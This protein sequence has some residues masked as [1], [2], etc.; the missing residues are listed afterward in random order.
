M[1]QTPA[2]VSKLAARPPASPPGKAPEKGANNAQTGFAQFLDTKS[3]A[4]ELPAIQQAASQSPVNSRLAPSSAAPLKGRHDGGSAY[5]TGATVADAAESGAGKNDSSESGGAVALAGS[6]SVGAVWPPTANAGP[7]IQ[8]DSKPAVPE[9]EAGKKDSPESGNAVAL[10]LG[11]VSLPKVNIDPKIKNDPVAAALEPAK[12]KN[13]PPESSNAV[14]LAGSLGVGAVWLPP[15]IMGP[16]IQNDPKAAAPRGASDASGSAKARSA[17]EIPQEAIFATKSIKAFSP[18]SQQGAALSANAVQSFAV[19][20]R[21]THFAADSAPSLK[22]AQALNMD[23]AGKI[24]ESGASA[25]GNASA[26]V[27]PAPAREHMNS[28]SERPS[29]SPPLPV[30]QAA[31]AGP[32][33]GGAVAAPGQTPAPPTQQV[34]DAIK[35]A[36]PASASAII[37]GQTGQP[38]PESPGPVKRLTIALEPEGLGSVS[39]ELSIKNSELGVRLEASQTDTAQLLKRDNV[40]LAK[41]LE[42]AGYAIGSVSVHIVSQPPAA[43]VQPQAP[44][45]GQSAFSSFTSMGG[46]GGNTGAGPQGGR[47]DKRQDRKGGGYGLAD[48]GNRDPHLYI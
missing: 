19:L 39:V 1:P 13:A 36:L 20:D 33:P 43:N 40:E 22:L 26:S 32:N 16:E 21:Q 9:P 17:L 42:A 11:A 45:N 25:A 37:A 41:A 8:H 23:G 4:M 29:E 2:I 47:A 35:T 18:S 34:L 30:L 44:A 31:A 15:A 5:R 14:A 27:P 48:G 3:G 24:D 46:G 6:L 28:H 10:A 12:R 7:E 38:A